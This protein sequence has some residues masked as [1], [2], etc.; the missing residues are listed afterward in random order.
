MPS[1][2]NFFFQKNKIQNKSLN[3][4]QP[5]MGSAIN[6]SKKYFEVKKIGKKMP[7]FSPNF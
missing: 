4:F 1:S 3:K 2:P 6:A 7:I 5:I